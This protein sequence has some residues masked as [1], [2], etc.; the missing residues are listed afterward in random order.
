MPRRLWLWMKDAFIDIGVGAF[1]LGF[2]TTWFVAD[3]SPTQLQMA[4]VLL[5]IGAILLFVS[6][7]LAWAV[8]E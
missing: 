5:V 2:G 1:I 7:A 6:L 3:L 8:G 4:V